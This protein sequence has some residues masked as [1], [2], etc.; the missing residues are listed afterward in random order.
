MYIKRNIS[1]ILSIFIMTTTFSGCGGSG[2]SDGSNIAIINGQVIDGPVKEV[3]VCIDG[4]FNKVC[5]S[6]EPFDITDSKGKF[7][8]T[9]NKRK[10][11]L[12]APL[13]AEPIINK[14]M[15]TYTNKY[16]IKSLSAYRLGNENFIYI[17]DLSDIVAKEIYYIKENDPTTILTSIA[18]ANLNNIYSK[19]IFG[20]IVRLNQY[21]PLKNKDNLV[22][23]H[24]FEKLKNNK[25]IDNIKLLN[26]KLSDL[27]DENTTAYYNDLKNKISNG[28]IKS[29]KDLQIALKLN[30]EN[31]LNKILNGD[32]LTDKDI[33]TGIL[34][35]IND[36]Q[37]LDINSTLINNIAKQLANSDV[38]INNLDKNNSI[39]IFTKNGVIPLGEV[40]STYKNDDNQIVMEGKIP[41][42]NYL[43][44]NKTYY[45]SFNNG[46]PLNITNSA[47]VL[48]DGKNI[49]LSFA[50]SYIND[51]NIAKYYILK[52]GE[53]VIKD[54]DN[55]I[56]LIDQ[57]GNKFFLKNYNINGYN[58]T[59]TDKNNNTITYELSNNSVNN[60]LF[61][62]GIKYTKY[63]LKND[64]ILIKDNL[65]N[66][67]IL[68]NPNT[69]QIS[70]ISNV[71]FDSIGNVVIDDV[72]YSLQNNILNY[73]VS[74]IYITNDGSTFIVKNNKVKY[75]KSDGTVIN[76]PVNN[77]TVS[78]G[79]INISI[80]GN[81]ETFIIN[82][83]KT[84]A[85]TS[86]NP[87]SFNKFIK[88]SDGNY[89]IDNNEGKYIISDNEIIPLSSYTYDS[90]NN[91][92]DYT[93]ISKGLTDTILG[94]TKKLNDLNNNE[95]IK[96]LYL[97]INDNIITSTNANN[98]Y[99]IDTDSNQTSLSSYTID[100]NI[101]TYTIDGTSNEENL[102][103]IN[104]TI[105]NLL[106]DNGTIKKIYI[107]SNKILLEFNNGTNYLINK[108][109]G[110]SY[111]VNNISENLPNLSCDIIS[112][113]T[114]STKISLN[115]IDQMKD[116]KNILD[117]IKL[118]NNDIIVILNNGKT[119]LYNSEN[120]IYTEISDL[121]L[122]GNTVSYKKKNGAVVTKNVIDNLNN[123]L[124]NNNIETTLLADGSILY[125]TLNNYIL[126]DNNG[127]INTYNKNNV[128]FN[129][130]KT[131]SYQ[132]TDTNGIVHTIVGT[133]NIDDN[134][135]LIVSDPETNK[136][137]LNIGLSG[138]NSNLEIKVK[139]LKTNETKLGTVTLADNLQTTVTDTSQAITFV[140]N[141][142]LPFN[143]SDLL[144]KSYT[145]QS[146]SN[147]INFNN[148]GIAT[149][150]IDKVGIIPYYYKIDNNVLI[151]T[152]MYDP[153]EII[154]YIPVK[155]I[156]GKHYKFNIVKTKNNKVIKNYKDVLIKVLDDKYAPY[157]NSFIQSAQFTPQAVDYNNKTFYFAD[158]SYYYLTNNNIVL[159]NT[160]N[161]I[162]LWVY[163][164]NV[165]YLSN[166]INKKFELGQKYSN[167]PIHTMQLL[168]LVNSIWAERKIFIVNGKPEQ[169]IN[170]TT[171]AKNYITDNYIAPDLT[172]SNITFT[173]NSAFPNKLD[174]YR[175][176]T[177]TYYNETTGEYTDTMIYIYGKNGLI[178]SGVLNNYYNNGVIYVN[179]YYI[180]FTKL[181]WN[182]VEANIIKVDSN[183][184]V[185][186]VYKA[187][188]SIYYNEY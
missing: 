37:K 32:I 131:V 75:I 176:T 30:N 81:K 88:L 52:N 61:K 121:I 123:I 65:D 86:L 93:I 79:S 73:Q 133:W 11:S 158:G 18:I 150:V 25:K 184:K 68:Y 5:D 10:I 62:E 17:T 173:F 43:T 3:K 4:N 78:D 40:F 130:N 180:M 119:L 31:L 91:N 84:E 35:N 46:L 145:K 169:I 105:Q 6:T 139:N 99:L 112:N 165:L 155:L 156:E 42:N 163:K 70:S 67:Y 102:S 118:D 97:T 142:I 128:S 149:E 44:E 58:I 172:N 177:Y 114:N 129:K 36:K 28:N 161:N 152:N 47:S 60:E 22:F 45:V 153:N 122:K 54:N 63:Y 167:G 72:S 49:G 151:L 16:F 127:N 135:N 15:D 108:N 20:H 185:V 14:S 26:N 50:N 188:G 183:K 170:N 23:F 38:N 137:L 95:E 34:L 69:N 178:T 74:S 64:E 96:N 59:L 182:K 115:L 53:V 104:S 57:N 175:I 148:N 27:L 98:D 143:I 179:G 1:I 113:N 12:V 9:Y 111:K 87:I 132:Y 124:S 89:L 140:K 82:K 80:N 147:T 100:G 85:I 92:I 141:K 181:E 51:D 120:N 146:T 94:Q 55:N 103:S 107:L 33:I 110:I 7:N 117:T 21:N 77:F 116:E 159:S 101:I 164:N 136:T 39:P 109:S 2:T 166:M 83:T 29:V 56:F 76:I 168:D 186:N 126:V 144:G 66:S 162:G 138:N 134:G 24:F 154:Y 174:I 19:N 160:F 157:I 41:F 90:I 106:T 171:D 8:I 71:S 48:L 13:I 187:N 125:K